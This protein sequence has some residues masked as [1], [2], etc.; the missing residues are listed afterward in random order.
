MVPKCWEECA[1]S[2]R[3]DGVSEEPIPE[4]MY[5]CTHLTH[6]FVFLN[7]VDF[8]QLCPDA[9]V[10]RAK[11]CFCLKGEKRWKLHTN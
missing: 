2:Q 8:L 9:E 4:A 5:A 3:G 11:C 1:H 7:K 10:F 6:S